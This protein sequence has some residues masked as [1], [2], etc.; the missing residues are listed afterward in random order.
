MI[1]GVI[2]VK[3][4]EKLLHTQSTH[5]SENVMW[6]GSRN[7]MPWITIL[8]FKVPIDQ[9]VVV[10]LGIIVN[11]SHNE[12]L[13]ILSSD[14]NGV[15]KGGLVSVRAL[16]VA[17]QQTELYLKS[18]D[19]QDIDIMDDDVRNT[20]LFPAFPPWLSFEIVF[21]F[22]LVLVQMFLVLYGQVLSFKSSSYF[23]LK[24]FPCQLYPCWILFCELIL[25][26]IF[27]A[28]CSDWD[29]MGSVSHVVLSVC[30]V[31]IIYFSQDW[32]S[33][34]MFLSNHSFMHIIHYVIHLLQL[35]MMVTLVQYL[36]W[37]LRTARNCSINWKK[38]GLRLNWMERGTSGFWNLK[39]NQ[40][41]E[42]RMYMY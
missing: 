32:M 31:S 34:K 18:K 25:I 16:E 42:V 13:F 33:E 37:W 28:W 40:E 9:L 4:G 29:A 36:R 24:W 23:R 26:S 19:H 1:S 7:Y 15:R 35:V 21:V 39:L 10:C 27:S 8:Q 41:A 14:S 12:D 17:M 5:L 30:A 20:R 22:S 2:I 11:A 38:S 3:P 6:L